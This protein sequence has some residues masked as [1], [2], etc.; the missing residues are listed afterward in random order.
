VF[1]PALTPPY[2][3][4]RLVLIKIFAFL[5]YTLYI[6]T[7][8]FEA[9][10]ESTSAFSLALGIMAASIYAIAYYHNKILFYTIG[11]LPKETP[12]KVQHY[13]I[14]GLSLIAILAAI[15]ATLDW[16]QVDE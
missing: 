3:Q 12:L 16:G 7:G 13:V 15:G 11:S 10:V 14:M 9:Y 2:Q 6:V 1:S 8:Y 5:S 4:A